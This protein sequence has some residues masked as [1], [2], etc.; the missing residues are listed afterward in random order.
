M[1][2]CLSIASKPFKFLTPTISC[3]SLL[4]ESKK[5]ALPKSFKLS[6]IE[7]QRSSS[8]LQKINEFSAK[9]YFFQRKFSKF[10]TLTRLIGLS[11][12]SSSSSLTLEFSILL[13]NIAAF[14][15]QEKWEKNSTL[16]GFKTFT[17]LKKH[18]NMVRN[19]NTCRF[20]NFFI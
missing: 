1:V 11:I 12:I 2:C 5:T 10:F 18:L 8:M 15:N 4:L 14:S 3:D 6:S 16:D 7:W 13:R 19:E 9:S 17:S 20:L